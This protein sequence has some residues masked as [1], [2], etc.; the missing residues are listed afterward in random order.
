[1]NTCKNCNEPISGNYCSGCGQ[2]AKLRR[3]DGRYILSEIGDFFFANKGMLYTVKKVL[4]TPGESIRKFLKEDR[5]RFVK[6]VTFVIVTSLIF[7]FV[8]FL[9][10]INAKNFQLYDYESVGYQQQLGEA[11]IIE[12]PTVNLFIDWIISHNGYASIIS[13]LFVA[14]FV[15]LFFRKKGYNIFEIFVLLCFISGVSSLFGSLIFI[16]QGLTHL[17][18]IHISLLILTSYSTWAIGQFFDKK[19]I[20]SYIKAFI[21]YLLGY[22]LFGF[23]LALVAAFIDIVIK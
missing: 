8:S 14:F 7:A 9:F 22:I 10:D 16:V 3:I 20:S 5:Y 6:P 18:L 15:N 17:N 4:I 19:K 23:I 12:L 21:S 13:G 2:P 11:D 1:M